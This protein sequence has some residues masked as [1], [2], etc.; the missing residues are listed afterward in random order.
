M[1]GAKVGGVQLMM[2]VALDGDQIL[3]APLFEKR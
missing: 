3:D 2:L 1:A